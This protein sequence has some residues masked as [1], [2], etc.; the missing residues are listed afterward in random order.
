LISAGVSFVASLALSTALTPVIRRA[1][2]AKG[3][4]DRV[5]ASR[6][7]HRAPVPRLGGIAIVLFAAGGF[8]AYCLT[9]I[10]VRTELH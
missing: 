7:V 2:V 8:F 1:A 3:W 6:K 4:L 10:K 5:D 9:Q